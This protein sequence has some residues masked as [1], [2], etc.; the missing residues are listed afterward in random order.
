[1]LLKLI[2]VLLL[3]AAATHSVERYRLCWNRV[4]GYVIC[5]SC[6]SNKKMLEG[7]KQIRSRQYPYLKIWIE[8]FRF[9]VT[10]P[11]I[12]TDTTGLNQQE[13]EQQ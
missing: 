4:E 8:E 2:P 9:P 3:V 5:G 13:Q 7:W 12:L 11:S 10:D 1:M 6:W